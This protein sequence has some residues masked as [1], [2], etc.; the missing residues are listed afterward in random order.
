MMPISVLH[1]LM[2]LQVGLFMK[3]GLWSP[4]VTYIH[5]YIHTLSLFMCQEYL[6]NEDNWGHQIKKQIHLARI[7][8]S[9]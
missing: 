1:G 9:Q 2:S 6:P 5:T 8:N 7:N 3:S 4:S